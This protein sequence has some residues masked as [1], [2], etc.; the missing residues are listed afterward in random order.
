MVIRRIKNPTV[1]EKQ[2]HTLRR[3]CNECGNELDP[4]ANP[5]HRITCITC[6]MKPENANRWYLGSIW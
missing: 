3:K 6:L 2:V 4:D 1:E 5:E